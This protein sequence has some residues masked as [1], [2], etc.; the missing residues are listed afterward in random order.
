MALASPR[1]TSECN[2]GRVVCPE[3]CLS[4]AL[5]ICAADKALI[6]ARNDRRSKGDGVFMLSS[7]PK[8]RSVRPSSESPGICLSARQ[9]TQKQYAIFQIYLYQKR[10][11][12][13]TWCQSEAKI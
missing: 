6:V 8:W 10:G 5:Q 9:N 3:F 12:T 13:D 2:S 7:V 1:L 4:P 11:Q